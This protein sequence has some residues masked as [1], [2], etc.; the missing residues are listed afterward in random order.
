MKK[1][2]LKKFKEKLCDNKKTIIIVLIVLLFIGVYIIYE[3]YKTDNPN[4]SY[5]IVPL[6]NRDLKKEISIDGQIVPDYEIDLASEI[7]GIISK[8]YVKEGDYVKKGQLLMKLKDTDLRSQ[9]NSS[10][11]NQKINMAALEKVENP[12]NNLNIE[13]EINKNNKDI[14]AQNIKKMKSNINTY[15]DSL[16]IYLDQLLRMN[17]DNYFDHIDTSPVFTYRIKSDTQ[18]SALEEERKNLTSFYDD[19]KKMNSPSL[20][21]T[22]DITQKF[23]SMLNNLYL[24]SIDFLG[25]S[26]I[27]LEQKEKVLSNLKNEIS[28]KKNNLI[29]LET[30]LA[31]LEKQ[32][33]SNYESEKKLNNLVSQEDIKLAREKIN[34]SKVQTNNA[35]LQLQKTN[36]RAIKSGIISK[37]FK[38]EGEYAGPS[39]PLIKVISKGKYVKALI[40]EVDIAKIK[41]NMPVDI[42][43]DAYGDKIFKGKIDLIYPTEKK[44]QG[45]TYYEIKISLDEKEIKDFNI[46]P[47]MSLDVFIVYA[48]KN[49]IPSVKR[50]IAKKDNQGYFVQ[51]LNQD[52][53]KTI[54]EKFVNKYFKS[55]F[56][57]DNYVE[58]ISGL[59]NNDSIIKITDPIIN[60][61]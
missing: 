3:K 13:K 36:I 26:D 54:E 28:L 55:G 53:S 35:Y 10:Y 17:I 15:I 20:D 5:E 49:N 24:A 22:V 31:Q 29:S 34:L 39:S 33:D 37:I 19:Y 57:G 52:K 60:N 27:E 21:D 46:L 25:F 30:Q 6:E 38:E 50:G 44:S 41:L 45:I 18:M 16:N 59:D 12:D 1:I 9:I 8:I 47:G 56:V 2:N 58:V 11:A 48:E 4:F 14:V 7:P 40:P 23:E 51:V 43:F 61:K 42:K 32:L